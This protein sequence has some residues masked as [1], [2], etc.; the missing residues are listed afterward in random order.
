MSD[1]D[2]QAPVTPDPVTDTPQVTDTSETN[3][4]ATNDAPEVTQATEAA[5]EATPAEVKTE[6][7]A[8]EKL[9]AGKYKSVEDLE[10]AYKNA[11]S[12]LHEESSQKAEL[13]RILNESFT[14]TPEVDTVDDYSGI[15]PDDSVKRDIAVMKFIMSHGE[16]DGAAM[17]EVLA[18]D[19]LISQIQ[20]H[21]AKLEY[22]YAKAQLQNQGKTVAEAT[23]QAQQD[24]QAKIV[25]KQ[26]AQV[27]TA[28]KVTDVNDAS[29]QLGIAT[30][31][32]PEQ[33][34]EARMKLIR[35]HLTK[36]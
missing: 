8:Q 7:T 14:P 1:V 32:T 31:G 6:D 27:E 18:N 20:G 34:E 35:Q 33:R 17:S 30:S 3:Q 36:L 23:K 10:N 19:P 29:E 24:T 9:L 15:E 28:Q 4:L 2:T 22:A 26:A 25:E 21:E 13:T 12:K 11:E 16:A 5:Q